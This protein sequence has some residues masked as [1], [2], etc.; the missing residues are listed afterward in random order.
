MADADLIVVATFSSRPDAEMARSALE[1][2]G[3]DAIV[4][5]DDAGGLQPGLWEGRGVAV[6]VRSADAQ[7]AHDILE[8]T[9][10][11]LPE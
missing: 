6:V 4:Q 2:A 10:R 9:A 3:I 1:A 11:Q 5:S 8:T 7:A